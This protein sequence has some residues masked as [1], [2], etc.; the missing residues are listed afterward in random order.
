MNGILNTMLMGI[1]YYIIRTCPVTLNKSA[2]TT[3]LYQLVI[4]RMPTEL[5]AS[6]IS[7]VIDMGRTATYSS[8]SETLPIIQ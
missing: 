4:T 3:E 7:N 1:P 5:G 2:W 6:Q 8:R